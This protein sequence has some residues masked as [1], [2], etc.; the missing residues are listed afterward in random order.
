MVDPL[1]EIRSFNK[2]GA[3]TVETISDG[4]PYQYEQHES[5]SRAS[6][7]L[8]R[9]SGGRG[10]HARAGTCIDSCTIHTWRKA[11]REKCV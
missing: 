11:L 2:F 5:S 1:D 6:C 8:N 3:L 7:C 10:A 4:I 9:L